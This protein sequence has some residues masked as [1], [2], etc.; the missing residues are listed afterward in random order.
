MII[1]RSTV[2]KGQNWIIYHFNEVGNDAE[3]KKEHDISMTESSFITGLIL[4][5]SFSDSKPNISVITMTL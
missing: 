1:L 3:I 5:L 2:T 4:L